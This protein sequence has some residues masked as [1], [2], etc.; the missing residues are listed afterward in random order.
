MKPTFSA[1]QAA[2]DAGTLRDVD[3]YL[4]RHLLALDETAGPA[5]ALA[6]AALSR[7]NADGDVCLDLAACAGTRLFTGE[8]NRH[9]G[10]PAPALADW[11][12]ALSRSV[13]VA[14]GDDPGGNARPLVLD[15]ANRLYLQKYFAWERAIVARLSARIAAPAAAA[16]AAL[17]QALSVAFP[18]RTDTDAQR[19]A[20][21]IAARQRFSVV[22]GGPGT[23]KTTTV[24]R[25]L[26][27]LAQLDGSARIALAA[28]TGKA[29]ARLSESVQGALEKLREE[30]MPAATLAR[31]PVEAATLHRL[32][33]W[34]PR[35]FRHHA[36]NPLPLDVLVVDEASMIDLSLMARLLEAVPAPAR[37]VLLGD[38]DQLASVEAGNV[39]G[40][41]CNHGEPPTGAPAIA[42]CI[43]A[44]THSHRFDAGSGIGALARAVNDGDTNAA[45]AALAGFA[46]L[47]TAELT[48]AQLP[49]AVAAEARAHLA[50]CRQAA[51]P[52]QALAAFNDFRFLCALREGPF[53][54]AQV[55][56]L[57]ERALEDAGLIDTRSRHYEGRPLLVT[58][59]DYGVQLFNGDTG[60]VLRDDDGVLRAFFPQ[61]RDGV[62]R[63]ALNR[64]PAHETCYAM[65]VHKSQGSEFGRIVLVLPVED[66]P[67]LGRELVYTGITRARSSV[68]LWSAPAVLA[69]AIARRTRR[70]S[71]LRDALWGI[72]ARD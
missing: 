55:N 43:A 42:N 53:G 41:L 11:L 19:Q 68:A 21:A 27:V 71:G 35:G 46:D 4:A 9:G 14:R 59:N 30:G 7:A 20:A 61:G 45:R 36:G 56:L 26:A 64:L 16:P 12:A 63:I 40:D 52:A 54:V 32:L 6:I 23:G 5:V 10:T 3:L 65:T 67:V 39:L 49:A 34:Q 8:D 1:L 22:T 15:N 24:T 29:A 33:G 51:T 70:S 60:L 13:L 2:R 72:A 37:L 25:L 17:E 47:E 66:S 48:A 38:R 44:L 57:C 28:P 18:G 31:I 69:G 62:R 50:A 58:Q